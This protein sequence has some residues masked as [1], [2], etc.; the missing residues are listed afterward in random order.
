MPAGQLG[1]SGRGP[2]SW[3]R[4]APRACQPTHHVEPGSGHDDAQPQPGGAD[5]DARVEAQLWR[6]GGEAASV[7]CRDERA[8]GSAAAS[9]E[10]QAGRT[11]HNVL[12]GVVH[13]PS[14]GRPGEREA[15]GLAHAAAP[16]APPRQPGEAALAS[17]SLRGPHTH[18]GS[19]TRRRTSRG[20]KR[21]SSSEGTSVA[22]A[23]TSAVAKAASSSLDP[24][25][26]AAADAVALMADGQRQSPRG[27]RSSL[28][29]GDRSQRHPARA[30]TGRERRSR[31]ARECRRSKH[32][33]AAPAAA[34]SLHNI[35]GSDLASAVLCCCYSGC[36][37]PRPF[38]AICDLHPPPAAAA[39]ADATSPQPTPQAP[40]SAR[41][42]QPAA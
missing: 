14:D 7:R 37:T 5:V 15:G 36:C 21:R 19:N 27:V 3:R 2:L 8:S 33:G 23:K 12:V 20:Q 9:D 13:G 41:R 22:A 16:H 26:D 31:A 40:P 39:A 18:R 42:A 35:G 38:V 30:A 10:P 6:V 17:A 28:E 4:P 11:V 29:A 25:A 1:S 24:V 32:G 34:M